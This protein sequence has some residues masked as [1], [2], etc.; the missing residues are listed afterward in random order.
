MQLKY[1]QVEQFLLHQLKNG[2]FKEGDKFYSEAELKAK[3]EVSSATVIKAINELVSKGLLTRQQGKGT[4]VSKAR[5]G[6]PVKFFDHERFIDA[7]EEVTVHTIRQE[8][9]PR[10]LD[11]L[12]LNTDDSYYHIVRVRK[13]NHVPVYVQHTY[14]RTEYF[15]QKALV[16][17]NY[18]ASVYE[19]I[20]ADSGIDLF[21]APMEETTKIIFPVPDL[22]R[23][24]LQLTDQQPAAFIKR[25]SYLLNNQIIEYVESYK[26]WD[27]FEFQIKSI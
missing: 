25:H 15:N 20:R 18:Y 8:N 9:E 2:D 10:I 7:D 26:K 12:Q 6:Q 24:L 23:Q 19:R 16:D 21:N 3:F 4:F 11:E 1:Q 13:M 27:Y 14:L 5:Q 17:Q 22:E